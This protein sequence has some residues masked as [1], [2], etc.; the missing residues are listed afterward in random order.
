M[1]GTILLTGALGGVGTMLRPRL[2][3]RYGALRISGR[4][5]ET[6]VETHPGET[7]V[8]AELSDLD[9]CLAATE[10]VRA[11]I[12]LGGQSVEAPWATILASNIDGLVNFYEACRI[13]RVERIVFAS[14]NHAVGFYPRVRK[15]GVD[16]PVRPDTRYGLSKAFGEALGAL[17]AD[18]FG[19][20]VLDIRI[21]NVAEK[22]ADRRRLAIWLHPDDLMQLCVIGIEHPDLHHEIVYG[23]SENE[24]AWW[25]NV[26]AFRLG[27]RPK[28]RAEDH[29][30][31]ALAEQEKLASD[32]IGDMLQGGGFCTTEFEG[33]LERVLAG[34]GR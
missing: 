29:A 9:Q 12:H 21:G 13:N 28:H 5:A 32:S 2:L 1:S 27:Y 19:L 34:R 26:N 3:E 25:D 11:A 31:H 24:R 33:D 14:S 17:Y 23:A 8:A 4:A 6:E 18:K 7:Y 16:A 30:A 15:I 10:G 20:R 22:P